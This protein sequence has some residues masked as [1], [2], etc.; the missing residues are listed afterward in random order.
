VGSFAHPGSGLFPLLVSAMLGLIGLVMLV[1]SW[2]EQPTPIAVKARPIAIVLT[3]L[4]GFALIARHLDVA[5]AI[6]FLVFVAALAGPQYSV[7]RN[8]KICAG[9]L[10]IAFAFHRLLGLNLTIF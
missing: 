5:A 4:A 10:A 3:S 9:L 6:V 7:V 8:L 1:R 2:L